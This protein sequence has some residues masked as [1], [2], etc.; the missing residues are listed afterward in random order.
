MSQQ[1]S[2]AYVRTLLIFLVVGAA[3]RNAGAV[4]ITYSTVALR[5]DGTMLVGEPTTVKGTV[6]VEGSSKAS[7]VAGTYTRGG[8]TF[9]TSVT[10]LKTE[11][12]HAAEYD[13]KTT[14]RAEYTIVINSN[15]TVDRDQSTVTFTTI[16][17]TWK[18]DTRTDAFTTL[19][20]TITGVILNDDGS[21]RSFEFASTNWYPPDATGAAGLN[22]EGLQGEINLATGESSYTAS[23]GIKKNGAIDSYAVSG[24]ITPPKPFD[25]APCTGADGCQ[26]YLA[27][28]P[29]APDV[30][31]PGT[32]V[33]VLTGF[34]FLGRVAGRVRGHGSTS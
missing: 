6:T 26:S 20:I 4:P 3:G 30:P 29:D 16:S 32:W 10:Q 15:G 8:E 18:G 9:T 13:G 33:M 2:I 25:E 5:P 28:A 31:E 7:T 23:Y 19:P 14:F 22:N 24:K 34:G 27:P 1:L 17:W 11:T 21:V 12:D